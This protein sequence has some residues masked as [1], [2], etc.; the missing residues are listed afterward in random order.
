MN[1]L[2]LVV[3]RA[4]CAV[5]SIDQLGSAVI[6]CRPDHT[7]SGEVGYAAT[8]NKKL[9]LRAEKVLDMVLGKKHCYNSIEWDR[10][11]KPSVK[12]WK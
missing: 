3:N 1:F 10:A 6:F 2:K 4:Y 12:I 5:L 11:G 8:L 9:A 7:V